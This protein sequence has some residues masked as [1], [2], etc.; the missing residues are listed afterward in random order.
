MWTRGIVEKIC[1]LMVLI[2][3]IM[4]CSAMTKN[5]TA[6]NTKNSK[7]SSGISK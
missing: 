5:D 3:L 2:S 6:D 7:L 4:G 1:L